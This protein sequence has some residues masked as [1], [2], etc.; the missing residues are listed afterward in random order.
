MSNTD[1]L[2]KTANKSRV[3]TIGTEDTAIIANDVIG[4]LNFRGLKLVNSADKVSNAGIS[5]IAESE[6]TATNNSSK[7]SFQTGAGDNAIENMSISSV[8]NLNIAGNL[9]VTNQLMMG[10]TDSTYHQDPPSAKISLGSG[11]GAP[12]NRT[13]TSSS[14]VSFDTTDYDTDYKF[15]TTTYKYTIPYSGKY[16]VTINFYINYDTNLYG[17]LSLIKIV[18]G[19]TDEISLL[20]S[21]TWGKGGHNMTGIFN[22]EKDDVIFVKNAG[23]NPIE[24][25]TGTRYTTMFISLINFG[26]SLDSLL[27]FSNTADKSITIKDSIQ[28]VVGKDLTIKADA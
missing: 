27:K 6:F 3:L 13:I 14:I 4:Q 26:T 23:S 19:T 2:N 18:V 10:G 22:L 25:G 21:N 1:D 28:S 7:L 24:L 20:H 12:S 16:I 5:S 17:K 11:T 15:N 9:T 8:G